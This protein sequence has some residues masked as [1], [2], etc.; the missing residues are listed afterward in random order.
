MYSK[1]FCVNLQCILLLY[2]MDEKITETP[3]DMKDVSRI[4]KMDTQRLMQLEARYIGVLTHDFDERYSRLVVAKGNTPEEKRQLLDALIRAFAAI[5]DKSGWNEDTYYDRDFPKYFDKWDMELVFDGDISEEGEG[6]PPA[7]ILPTPAPTLTE[8]LNE[9]GMLC[10]WLGTSTDRF[11]ASLQEAKK[12]AEKIFSQIETMRDG[13]LTRMQERL[14]E[15]QAENERLHEEV[16]KLRRWQQCWENVRQEVLSTYDPH[17]IA[18]AGGMSDPEVMAE[19]VESI[20]DAWMSEKNLMEENERLRQSQQ[21][22]RESEEYLEEKEKWEKRNKQSV[23]VDD[24]RKGVLELAAI[25]D[26]DKER[27]VNYVLYLN[28][29]LRGTAWDK[30]SGIILGEVKEALATTPKEGGTYNHFE[31]GSTAQVFNGD[32]KGEFNNK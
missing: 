12:H 4:R 5:H 21:Q 3:L 23:K 16:A 17:I 13:S 2:F 27:T 29:M 20:V 14:S 19:A 18:E 9:E 25:F 6:C 11:E 30:M 22:W 7:E 15:M 10:K 8:M 32:V 1:N 24:I 26:F 31:A 28:Q